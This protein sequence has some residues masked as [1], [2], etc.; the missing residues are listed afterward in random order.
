M[1]FT[2]VAAVYR[3]TGEKLFDLYLSIYTK[4]RNRFPDFDNSHAFFCTESL[5]ISEINRNS[6]TGLTDEGLSCKM[7]K[8]K[9]DIMR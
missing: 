6:K 2:S 9:K 7:I 5:Y 8:K 1:F 3:L 4:I